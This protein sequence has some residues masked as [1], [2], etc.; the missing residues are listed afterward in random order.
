MTKAELA[1]QNVLNYCGLDDPSGIDISKI[2]LGR[3]AFY[4]EKPLK[5]K[6]GQIIS[7]GGRSIITIN[8]SI[9]F[10]PKKRFTTA[11]EL[12]HFELHKDYPIISD[13][14]N[15][16]I[17]WFQGNNTSLEIEAN[18]FA[19]ELLM[20]TAI[21]QNEC[22]KRRFGPNMIEYL[23]KRFKVSKTVA[24]L[25]FVKAG[26][27][28]IMVVFCKDNKMKWWKKS[29]DFRHYL[30]FERDKQPPTESVAYELFT[31]NKIYTGDELKQDIW[32]SD[33]FKM[34]S[35]ETEDTGFYEYCLFVKSYNYTI[36]VIWED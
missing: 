29:D 9:E 34:R 27:H 22:H 7:V 10:E 2:I 20:P 30:E 26:N 5:G 33:W 18:E 6:E 32:K 16:L 8:S 17:S 19:A 4:Y 24:I 21:F 23:A 31:T 3:G 15:D 12:G 35:D 1:A 28:P 36:S 14:E 13:T 11:H 25:K